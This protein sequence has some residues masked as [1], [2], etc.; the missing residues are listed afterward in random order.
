MDNSRRGEEW[1]KDEI[2]QLKQEYKEIKLAGQGDLTV[3]E[4]A[5]SHKRSKSAIRNKAYE[6]DFNQSKA[7]TDEEILLLKETYANNCKS[8]DLE[9]DKLAERMRR[10]ESNICR[11][12]R[13]LNLTDKN[14]AKNKDLREEISENNKKWYANHEHPKGMEGKKHDPESF[15]D[16]RVQKVETECPVCGE[17]LYVRPKEL[18]NGH[19]R[20]CSLQ[21]AYNDPNRSPQTKESIKKQLKTKRKNGNLAHNN[22][23][24]KRED[25]EGQYFRSTWEANYARFLNLQN[26]E[27]Q[28]E[29]KTFEFEPIKRGTRFYTPDFYLP[30]EDRWVEIKGW[31]NKKSQTKIKRFKKYYKEEFNKMTIVIRSLNHKNAG[32]AHDIGIPNIQSYNAI[33]DKVG[34]LIPNWE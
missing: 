8:G 12:A 11:K 28:Y 5:Q 17:T 19:T 10:S 21:C 15:E 23:Q 18:E 20:Y 16:K 7:W 34:D 27:W 31:F 22:A 4:I 24:G 30:D 2:E 13:E 9:L 1:T 6:E 26:T 29:P 32:I 14:R 33:R 3:E 25:L